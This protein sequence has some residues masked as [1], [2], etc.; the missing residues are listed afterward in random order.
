K[1][2]AKG[3]GLELDPKL[4]QQSREA[5]RAAGVAERTEFRVQDVLQADIRVTTLP[6]GDDPD[7]LVRRD[8]EALRAL[9]REALPVADHLFVAVTRA[10]DAADPRSRS[11]AVEALLPTIAAM[12]DP[13]VKSHYVQRLAR[14][15]QVDE[16]T[17][18]NLLAQRAA[19]RPRPVA[20][21]REV[22]AAK[23]Q[24]AAPP[25]GETQLL[26]LL[27][28]R[29]EARGAGVALDH[30]TFEDSVNR[31]LFAAWAE[32]VDFEERLDEFD[33]S[34]RERYTFL[35]ASALPDYDPK[36]IGPMVDDMAQRLRLG[37]AAARLRLTA[38]EQAQSLRA[39][40]LGVPVTPG[41]AFEEDGAVEDLDS[42]TDEFTQTIQRQREL[43]RAYQIATGH[44]SAD[45][46][47]PGERGIA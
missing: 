11:R 32:S 25:D 3:L 47:D 45:D 38:V 29:R 6:A 28:Q 43:T 40:R 30:D 14:I 22:A 44:R 10:T 15:G 31:A 2:G 12:A 36:H 16:R 9:I 19:G 46:G 20:T 1:F 35:M 41:G 8:P 33:E 7:S 17:V 4:V 23:K 37:R 24:P 26:R 5:A 27:V 18:L 13:V 39:A 34:I 42:A 21:P